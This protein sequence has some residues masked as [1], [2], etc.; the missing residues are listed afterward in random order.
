M[1]GQMGASPAKVVLDSATAAVHLCLPCKAAEPGSAMPLLCATP[2]QQEER[3]ACLAAATRA[4]ALLSKLGQHAL[5]T[6]GV[7]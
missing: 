1:R 6:R 3:N 2:C 5:L 4:D 7:D